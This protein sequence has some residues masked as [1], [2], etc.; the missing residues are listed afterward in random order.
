MIKNIIKTKKNNL[1]K[2]E[3]KKVDTRLLFKIIMWVATHVL[4]DINYLKRLINCKL[5]YSDEERLIQKYL[6]IAEELNTQRVSKSVLALKDDYFVDIF[7]NFHIENNN[8]LIIRQN[9]E[10]ISIPQE[11]LD[12]FAQLVDLFII[13]RRKEQLANQALEEL[14]QNGITDNLKTLIDSVPRVPMNLPSKDTLNLK[15]IYKSTQNRFTIPTTFSYIDN[16]TNGIEQGYVNTLITNEIGVTKIFSIT[17]IYNA[18]CE[19]RN[20]LY[21]NN[22]IDIE[23]VVSLIVFK[24][25]Q[26]LYPDESKDLKMS[27]IKYHKIPEDSLFWSAYED[28]MNKY[29][30]QIKI[31]TSEQVDITGVENLYSILYSAQVSFINDT[32]HG[33]DFVVIEGIENL[34]FEKN[35]QKV[36]SVT[37]ALANYMPFLKTQAKHF[38]KTNNSI[39]VL[40][41]TCN[42]NM[43]DARRANA[44]GQID[45]YV[46]VNN[47][48]KSIYQYSDNII[49]LQNIYTYHYFNKAHLF[50]LYINKCKN[51]ITASSAIEVGLDFENNTIEKYY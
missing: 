32:E 48:D 36:S 50:N 46:A 31:L 6:K 35:Y 26:T 40:L 2:G 17:V 18:L 33:V 39:A 30:K 29:S 42:T 38:L 9:E 45:A 3:N 20:V 4:I 28:F 41:T 8:E 44:F 14:K 21:I 51:K 16:M 15:E 1:T 22:Y 27:D 10:T 5:L 37:T 49:S 13:E 25:C 47:I 12:D 7:K 11:L 19:G 34:S 23:E 43:K 24:H